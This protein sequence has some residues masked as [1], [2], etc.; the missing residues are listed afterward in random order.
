MP[1]RARLARAPPDRAQASDRRT[2]SSPCRSRRS[3]RA[4][5]ARSIRRSRLRSHSARSRSRPSC[6]GLTE[7]CASRPDGGDPIEHVEIMQRHLFGLVDAASGS[8]RAC[9]RIVVMPCGFSSAAARSASSICS[10]GM[11]RETDRRTNAVLRRAIP[12]PGIG[13][14]GEQHFPHQGISGSLRFVSASRSAT[15]R[16]FT[17]QLRNQ[18]AVDLHRRA[19]HV[20]R[21]VR[22]QER[23]DAA[24]LV[25]ARRTGRSGSPRSLSPSPRRRRCPASSR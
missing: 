10:P 5:S 25:G 1:T 22:E 6:V 8:R 9:V 13:R 19:G 16:A 20:R 4:A 7:I 15:R 18:P 14:T 23:A 12:Q 11:K 24:E 2:A 17:A 3:C 21:R